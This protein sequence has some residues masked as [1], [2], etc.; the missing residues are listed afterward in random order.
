M[1]RN[2]IAD[3]RKRK[4]SIRLYDRGFVV[5]CNSKGCDTATSALEDRGAVLPVLYAH[6]SCQFNLCQGHLVFVLY[7]R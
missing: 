5:A 4:A 7:L 1:N 2:S 6:Q 3:Y